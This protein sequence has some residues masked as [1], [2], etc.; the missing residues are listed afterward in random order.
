MVSSRARAGD[1]MFITCNIGCVPIINTKSGKNLI[2]VRESFQ[3]TNCK[4]QKKYGCGFGEHILKDYN[5]EVVST[6]KTQGCYTER[7]E[8]ILKERGVEIFKMNTE[9]TMTLDTGKRLMIMN[10]RRCNEDNCNAFK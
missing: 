3:G 1:D 5:G 2:C 8:K 4:T 10:G 9:G 7:D 6:A